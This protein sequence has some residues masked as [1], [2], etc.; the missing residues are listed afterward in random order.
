[1]LVQEVGATAYVVDVGARDLPT[2]DMGQV[3]DTFAAQAVDAATRGESHIEHT[4]VLDPE[5]GFVD[6]DTLW[7]PTA[8]TTEPALSRLPSR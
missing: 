5:E 2:A 8:W 7:T 3:S 1:M 4:G 6:D